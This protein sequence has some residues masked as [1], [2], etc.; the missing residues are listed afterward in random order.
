[1]ATRLVDKGW[2]T[3]FTKALNDDSSYL[4]IICPFIKAST[5]KRLLSQK[6]DRVRVITRANLA[7]FAA[8]VSD[9]AALRQLLAANTMLRGVRN[10]HAKLYIFGRSRAIITSANL[11]EAALTRNHEFGLVTDDRA[12]IKE[13]RAYFDKLWTRAKPDISKEQVEAWD[14]TVVGYRL[15][16]G[17][18]NTT[19][20]LP[21]YGADAGISNPATRVSLA[22]PGS[23]QGFV[24]FLGSSDNRVLR[25]ASTIEEIKGGG[26]HWAACYPKDR[27]P[28]QV[29]DGDVVYMG[30]LT[31]KPNGIYIIG[32][33]IGME[34]H[35]GRDDATDADI[36]C[37]SWKQDY[38]HYVRVY[39]AEFLGGTIENGISL[40]DLMDEL[41]ADSF[42]TTQRNAK[43]G[44]GNTNP[45]RAF[46]QQA[47]V[48]LSP[49]GF[50]WLSER[51]EAAFAKH[52]KIPS[53]TLQ[54]LDWPAIPSL[55]S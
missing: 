28:R 7:D 9:V 47:A 30:R 34:Y 32:R 27:R 31:E 1:M 37:R 39:D 54:S 51:L 14:E 10:L 44:E 41:R 2:D 17:S 13:C 36:E 15:K 24:K 53:E 18:P 50:S 11:T 4:R 33:A 49:E 23:R 20:E 40:Y 6:P 16:G 3:E 12:T 19:G 52:G 25:S 5:I 46:S 38:P 55:R 48:R 35:P 29:K 8:G 43:D 21:D 42:A 45:R 26:C 22:E